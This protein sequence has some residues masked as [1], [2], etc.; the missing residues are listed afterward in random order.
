[1]SWIGDAFYISAEGEPRTVIKK[2]DLLAAV[3]DKELTLQGMCDALSLSR[4]IGLDVFMAFRNE[5]LVKMDT[6]GIIRLADGGI[7]QS[8]AFRARG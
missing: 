3:R 4:R 5:E 2:A 7:R 6:G 1:M 8:R